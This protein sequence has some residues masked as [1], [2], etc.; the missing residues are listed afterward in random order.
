MD[1]LILLKHL[2][3]IV[4]IIFKVLALV[5]IFTVKISV[6]LLILDFLL[7]VLFVKTNDT[8]LKLLEISDVM[9]ALE[10]IILELLFEALLLIQLFPQMSDL[11][12][13]TLLSHP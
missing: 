4:H 10:D 1:I 12:G 6:T 13:E 3:Q 7:D 5:R 2:P 8:L 11:I 9:K